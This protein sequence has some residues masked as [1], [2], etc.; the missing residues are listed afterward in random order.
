M[1]T[2]A[3]KLTIFAF[4]SWKCCGNPTIMAIRNNK[5]LCS[6]S[7]QWCGNS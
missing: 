3:I 7:G 2:F 1:S 6:K 4:Y 5:A